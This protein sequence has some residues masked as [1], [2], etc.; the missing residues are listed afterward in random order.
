MLLPL[1]VLAP[2][3]AVEQMADWSAVSL[4]L[5]IE[6]E[7]QEEGYA[8]GVMIVVNPKLSE[9]LQAQTVMNPGQ[10]A[11]QVL[12]AAKAALE[13]FLGGPE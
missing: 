8:I 5:G 2:A 13:G 6:Q 4:S 9:A 10:V 11:A 7:G 3:Q 12:K 1:K